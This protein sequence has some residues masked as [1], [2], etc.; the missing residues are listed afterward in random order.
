MSNYIP[1]KTKGISMRCEICGKKVTGKPVRTKIDNSIMSTCND[2]SK[3]GKIQREPP[4]PNRGPG[5]R[6]SVG[7]R[8]TFRSHEP[9]HEVI[10]DYPGS[11]KVL[12][13][14]KEKIE[15]VVFAE[16]QN[17]D[18]L[19]QQL[20]HI[21]QHFANLKIIVNGGIPREVRGDS[22]LFDEKSQTDY[23]SF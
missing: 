5:S 11:G 7:R 16:G 20:D 8:R 4:R 12:S 10:E 3:F 14:I 6:G 15:S 17:F 9:T 13:G 2:C 1:T 21:L 23:L 22:T 18:R 19:E